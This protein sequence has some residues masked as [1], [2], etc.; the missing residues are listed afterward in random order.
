M[1][2]HSAFCLV[3][4]LLVAWRG[5]AQTNAARARLDLDQAITMASHLSLGMREEKA[6]KLLEA[7]G[8]Q[9]PL[10]VGCSHGWT[11]F[12]AL[13]N[14]SS[15]ALDIAPI[16]ARADGEW[17][18]GLLRAAFIQRN[19][20]NLAIALEPGVL[21]QAESPANEDWEILVVV[22]LPTSVVLAVAIVAITRKAKT[23]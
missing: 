20:T 15:L 16:R 11:C 1:N 18:N 6:I 14:G 12:Y 19:G 17:V 7:G 22:M 3:S 8:L 9:A 2:A 23:T 5:Q 4:L 10:K 13:G 21:P